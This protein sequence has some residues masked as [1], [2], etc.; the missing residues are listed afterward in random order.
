M[1]TPQA[2][3]LNVLRSLLG[4]EQWAVGHTGQQGGISLIKRKCASL[5]LC[6]GALRVAPGTLL[7]VYTLRLHPDP[8]WGCSPGAQVG[9]KLKSLI[10]RQAR[11]TMLSL[12]STGD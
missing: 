5:A 3:D 1:P 11:A 7:R 12:S 9:F 2:T 8:F 10:L 4:G 6:R